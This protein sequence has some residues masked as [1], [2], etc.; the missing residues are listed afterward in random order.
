MLRMVLDLD[1]PP[2]TPPT[3]L[4]C[5]GGCQTVDAHVSVHIIGHNAHEPV[6]I[7]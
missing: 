5:R 6:H 2:H 1:L 3:V 7:T 4:V